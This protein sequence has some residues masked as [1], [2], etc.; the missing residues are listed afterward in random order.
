M[1]DKRKTLGNHDVEVT[2]P[3]GTGGKV[4]IVETDKYDG[5]AEILVRVS[6]KRPVS[7]SPILGVVVK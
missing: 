1:N 6:K 7:D 5:K 3:K 4:H 2:V